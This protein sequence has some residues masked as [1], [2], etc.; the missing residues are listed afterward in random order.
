VIQ[1]WLGDRALESF[2]SDLFGREPFVLPDR[3]RDAAWLLD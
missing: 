1:N 3:A 2:K